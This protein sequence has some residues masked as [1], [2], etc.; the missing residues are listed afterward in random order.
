MALNQA[1]GT[2]MLS[3]ARHLQTRGRGKDSILAHITPREAVQLKNQG[4]RGSI[5]PT[6]GLLEFDD[7]PLPP[8]QTPSPPVEQVT[9]TA[10]A[11]PA[12]DINIAPPLPPPIQ[13]QPPAP[14]PA[15]QP[16][17]VANAAPATATTQPLGALPQ[18]PT[19][20]AP[21]VPTPRPAYDPNAPEDTSGG[22][23]GG[24][25]DFLAN[26]KTLLELGGLGALGLYGG[27]NS[28]NAGK[29]AQAL[30]TNLGNLAAPISAQGNAA[31]T[32]TMSGDLTPASAAALQAT[33]AQIAQGQSQ[34]AIS[35]QQAAGAISTT[36]ANLLNN[37]LNQA[38]QLLN[39]A[40]SYLRTAYLQGYQA[41]VANQT[42]TQNFYTN[43]ATLAARLSGEGGTTINLGGGQ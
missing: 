26:N 29:Q 28:A 4:G 25:T 5:N 7:T 40:D 6:T 27:V 14:L 13:A 15:A 20:N 43:L 17:P 33:Q 36:F 37:Q 8:D 19:V 3:L 34:G 32:S 11:Q 39:T 35:S 30:Q 12:P 9:S 38:L 23:G 24:V 16:A 18:Y 1:L 31:L 41:N 10:E 2:D 42:N 22:G 21:A